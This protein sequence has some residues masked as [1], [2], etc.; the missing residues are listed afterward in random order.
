MR[1]WLKWGLILSGIVFLDLTLF[2]ILNGFQITFGDSLIGIFSIFSLAILEIPTYLF[3]SLPIYTGGEGF[4]IAPLND[5][6]LILLIIIWF[7]IGAIIG[8]LLEK[9]QNNNKKAH[10]LKK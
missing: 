2:F 9:H 8:Y 3:S 4:I 7:V 10:K 5:F 6:G 1:K